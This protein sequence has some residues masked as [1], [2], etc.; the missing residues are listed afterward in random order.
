[1]QVITGRRN[2]TWILV[3]VRVYID[4]E[5]RTDHN[6]TFQHPEKKNLPKSISTPLAVV[7]PPAHHLEYHKQPRRD[8]Q[9]YAQRL[10]TATTITETAATAVAT[11]AAAA[12]VAVAE[13]AR[14]ATRLVPLPVVCY[15]F[16]SLLPNY[17]TTLTWILAAYH[18]HPTVRTAGLETRSDVSRGLVSKFFNF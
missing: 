18:H 3:W 2:L 16:G 8:A 1:M 5:V 10:S 15:F 14:D 7:R 6:V 11:A 12:L 4:W 17:L 13:G 9:R